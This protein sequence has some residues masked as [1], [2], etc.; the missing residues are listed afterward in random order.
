M[1]ETSGCLRRD[2]KYCEFGYVGD[3]FVPGGLCRE[4]PEGSEVVVCAVRVATRHKQKAAWQAVKLKYNEF[5][6]GGGD[7]LRG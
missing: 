1:K 6:K 7:V 2:N 4:I 3:V 5:N